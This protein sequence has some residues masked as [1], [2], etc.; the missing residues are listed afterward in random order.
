[1]TQ[2]GEDMFIFGGHLKG[3]LSNKLW[4]FDTGNIVI[5]HSIACISS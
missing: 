5:V 2:V 1:M 3:T 4:K